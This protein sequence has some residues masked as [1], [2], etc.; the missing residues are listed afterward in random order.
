M[1]EHLGKNKFYIFLKHFLSDESG[2][3]TTE[4]VLLVFFIV[5]ITISIGVVFRK[6][7]QDILDGTVGK[8]LV[9]T[10]FNPEGMYRLPVKIPN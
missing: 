5:T 3:A 1:K 8:F 4:Y 2:Q 9:K 7:I 6:K 10:F